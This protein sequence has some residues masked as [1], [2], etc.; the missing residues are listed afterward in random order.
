MNEEIQSKILWNSYTWQPTFL[1]YPG[2][3]QYMTS[4]S[5]TNST[6]ACCTNNPFN[7]LTGTISTF[8]FLCISCILIAFPPWVCHF[9]EVRNCQ[10]LLHS[11]V[12]RGRRGHQSLA[13]FPVITDARAGASSFGTQWWTSCHGGPRASARARRGRAAEP[14]FSIAQRQQSRSKHRHPPPPAPLIASF[15]YSGG[16]WS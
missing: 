5:F 6:L 15:N 13:A 11:P 3:I 8:F 4:D 2:S 12:Y 14:A 7:T 9:E 16:V 1:R 10:W